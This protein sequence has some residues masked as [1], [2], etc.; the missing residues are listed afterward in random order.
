MNIFFTPGPAQL[1]PRVAD[2]INE[3]LA[4]QFLS[5]SHR[6]STY[7]S[8]HRHTLSQLR[9]VFQLPSDWHI[10]FHASATEIWER[11]IQN[12]VSQRSFHFVNGSFSERYYR[13][14]VSLQVDAQKCE[15]SWGEGFDFSYAEPA[16]DVEMINFTR[17]ETSTG[18]MVPPEEIYAYRKAYPDALITVDMVSS[19]PYTA[20]DWSQIDAA[21]F[22]VQK[23]FGLP[24]GLG[25]LLLNERCMER[26]RMKAAKGESLGTYHS[27]L[28][29]HEKAQKF[30]TVETPNMLS[31]W[32]LG[33]VAEAMNQQGIPAL[34]TDI[35][36][37]AN[38]LYHL[39]D[40]HPRWDSFV[41]DPRFR[42][43][44]VIVA[45]IPEGADELR[46]QLE[47]RGWVVGNGYG[48]MKGKQI[49]IAN[50]PAVS[51][52]QVDQLIDEMQSLT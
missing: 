20:W 43:Q 41:K 16:Q 48:K 50:F 36:A 26:A 21:Y 47:T 19:A 7:E 24:A 14:A 34:R 30:Q 27:F 11:L 3:A 32:L 46:A 39:F 51:A 4:Q 52:E 31:I 10:F 25:V 29:Q 2:Y 1:Y 37:R 15:A 17:N 28:A 12:C 40:Q 6:S 5:I 42:S 8:V 9:E 13:A 23:C 49:R 35:Q 33:K 45:N 18:V 22:S 44:T 38:R